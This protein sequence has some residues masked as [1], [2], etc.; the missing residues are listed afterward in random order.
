MNQRAVA[1]VADYLSARPR[2]RIVGLRTVREG[3]YVMEIRDV[4]D[5][6]VQL[7]RSVDDLE[8]WIKS[9]DEG[10]CP[11]PVGAIC[12]V[13]DRVHTDRGVDGELFSHC[14]G[15]QVELIEVAVELES[16]RG[17]WQ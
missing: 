7:I 17:W 11:Q 9:F 14:V 6:R 2:G 12:G 16:E 1:L 4:R 5:G 10:R 13:C 15:C 8:I 3:D